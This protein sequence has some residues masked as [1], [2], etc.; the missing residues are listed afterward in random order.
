M[1]L[2][3][4]E[5]LRKEFAVR[6]EAAAYERFRQKE[7]DERDR[8]ERKRDEIESH[9]EEALDFAMA[10]VAVSEA[11]IQDFRIE[12]DTYDAA[13]VEA[14]QLNEV[15]LT[16]T[17]E[18]LEKIFAKAH[19]LP[20]GRRVFK[21]EDGQRV[22][23]EHGQELSADD[24]APQEIEDWRPRWEPTKEAIDQLEELKRERADLLEF[25]GKL[26]SARD[27]LDA[28]DLSR[29]EFETLREDLKSD[30]PDAVRSLLPEEHAS[31][32]AKQTAAPAL[33]DIDLDIEDDMVPTIAAGKF[34]APLPGG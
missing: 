1:A 26:D 27:R 13:T 29:E 8:R 16:A 32:D 21:T 31:V 7:L 17:R 25:Q 28:G 10:F 15:Q 33:P 2:M 30:M 12:L 3:L 24:I 9:A 14:L 18:R 34:A 23:D 19:V 20:D 4:A 22:F 6:T 5:M 11:E